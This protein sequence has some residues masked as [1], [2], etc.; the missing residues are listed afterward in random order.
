MEGVHPL[1]DLAPRDVVATAIAMRLRD[2]PGGVDD[3]V[4][5]DAT[6]IG[7][8]LERRFP[9]IAHACREAGIDPLHEPIPVAPAAHFACGGVRA[10]LSGGTSIRGLFAVGEVA[11]TGVHGANRLASNGVTE[12]LVAGN[13]VGEALG[14]SLPVLSPPL[15]TNRAK[16]W[17]DPAGRPERATAMSRWV[18]PLRDADGLAAMSALLDTAA[19]VSG[20]PTLAKL[21]ATN[22]HSVCRL[23]VQAANLRTESRGCHRRLDAPDS[24]ARWVGRIE[25]WLDHGLRVEFVPDEAA[26]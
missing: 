19:I 5:L 23:I 26:A 9:T 12:G 8:S 24:S 15:L 2:A 22:L 20:T 11:A 1:G 21:E 16:R 3:H 7:P 25:Q 10:D 18:G 17:V 13:R 4:L 14:K 6:S